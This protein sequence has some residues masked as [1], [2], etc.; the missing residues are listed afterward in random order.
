MTA[1]IIIVS[2]VVAALS[3][4]LAEDR[5]I[6]LIHEAG[7]EN[8]TLSEPERGWG[9]ISYRKI[10]LDKEGFST[11]DRISAG[12]TPFTFP[13]SKHFSRLEVE[14]LTLIGEINESGLV[15]IAGQSVTPI[16]SI[17]A[18]M[19][20][21]KDLLVKNAQITLKSERS[22]GISLQ[23]DGQSNSTKNGAELRFDL[24][25]TQRQMRYQAKVTAKINHAL[26]WEADAE[27]TDI[28]LDTPT[29]KAT[30][31]SG[32]LKI[33]GTGENP[34]QINGELRAGNAIMA[35]LPWDNPAITLQGNALTPS[36]IIGTK[37]AGYEDIELGIA[38]EGFTKR[39]KFSGYIYSAKLGNLISFLNKHDAL[40]V[41][42]DH[43]APYMGIQGFQLNFESNENTVEF[44]IATQTP[45]I[46]FKGFSEF[47]PTTDGLPELKSLAMTTAQPGRLAI[48][49][50][51][52]FSLIPASTKDKPTVENVLKNLNYKEVSVSTT[53]ENYPNTLYNVEIKGSSPTYYNNR[54]FIMD[55]SLRATFEELLKSLPKPDLSNTPDLP[56]LPPEAYQGYQG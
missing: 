28:R 1:L 39:E 52:F 36:I 27:I 4:K 37:A 35:G 10:S 5:L 7:F 19:F 23:I 29:I 33:I 53:F 8:A 47:T 26:N 2:G 6:K 51:E 55:F 24:I 46:F 45:E 21:G 9:K 34:P 25:N 54:P 11:L 31:A 48:N 40:K 44:D 18:N 50:K 14:G 13:L 16:D 22:G 42:K 32:E 3:P 43:F 12:F 49:K 30:R 41:Q 38:I 17:T 20:H 56:E 15:S